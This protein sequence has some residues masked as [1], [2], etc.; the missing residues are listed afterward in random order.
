MVV[1][2]HYDF[3]IL[4]PQLSIFRLEIRPRFDYSWF[5][6]RSN[7]GQ[8]WNVHGTVFEEEAKWRMCLV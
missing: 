5:V 1:I 2:L 4:S 7:E 8:Y 3:I 6:E